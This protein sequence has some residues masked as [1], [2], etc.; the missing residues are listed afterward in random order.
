MI[1]VVSALCVTHL[2]VVV[3]DNRV[4]ITGDEQAHATEAGAE[5]GGRSRHPKVI[6]IV[7]LS[8]SSFL[9]IDR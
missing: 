5:E 4:L 9:G 6:E 1:V 2:R 8:T 3:Q 7:C